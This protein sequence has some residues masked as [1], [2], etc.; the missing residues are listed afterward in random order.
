[1]EYFKDDPIVFDPVAEEENDLREYMLIN[2]D[3]IVGLAES[4]VEYQ[5]EAGKMAPVA[6]LYDPL[7]DNIFDLI[8][9]LGIK[10]VVT[11]TMRSMMQDELS[12]LPKL[13]SSKT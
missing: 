6:Y 7:F 1:M 8:Q 11:S 2:T 5:V 3:T 10:E 9:R 4:F 13:S 12:A